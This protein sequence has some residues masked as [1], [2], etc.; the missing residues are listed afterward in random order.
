MTEADS[1]VVCPHCQCMIIIESVNCG[2]FRHGV[3]KATGEQIPPHASKEICDDLA[4]RNAIY[5]C[6]K[7][8][9]I[10]STT[11]GTLVA[12]VCEYI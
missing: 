7:P 2:I 12:E 1:E 4:Q 9:R 6:G 11:S 5:G 3:V 10:V 8:F